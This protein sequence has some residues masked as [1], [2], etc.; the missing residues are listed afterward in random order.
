[1]RR[2]DF[3]AEPDMLELGILE[4]FFLTRSFFY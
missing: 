2:I 3:V 4:D 1:L